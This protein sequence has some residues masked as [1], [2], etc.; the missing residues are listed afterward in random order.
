M[1]MGVL[2][3]FVRRDD[4][5]PRHVCV[6]I[7]THTCTHTCT[8]IYVFSLFIWLH[9]V[10]VVTHGLSLVVGSADS[11]LWLGELLMVVASLVA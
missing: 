2:G 9:W 11:S 8:H 1:F 5:G 7:Y 6:Y 3:Y 4:F 10:F